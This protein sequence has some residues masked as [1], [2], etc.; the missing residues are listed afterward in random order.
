MDLVFAE[1]GKRSARFKRRG[2]TGKSAAMSRNGKGSA[3]TLTQRIRDLQTAIV[4]KRD[5]LDAHIEKMDDSNVSDADLEATNKLNAEI[6]QLE[7]TES[8]LV[9]AEKRLAKTTDENGAGSRSR[10]L[11][12]VVKP[13][14][15]SGTVS[16]PFV[17]PKGRKK[18]L[19]LV[20]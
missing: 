6:A 17:Q 10:A 16:A 11:S 7:K 13:A 20:D 1:T 9:E 18:D 15:G 19:D 2:F 5:E 8:A 3:M 4:A 14:A 12:T